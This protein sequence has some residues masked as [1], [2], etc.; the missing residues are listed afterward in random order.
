MAYSMMKDSVERRLKSPKSAEFPGI[1]ESAGHVK[2]LGNQNYR[3][4]SWVD[5]QNSF[6]ANI[7]TYFVGEIKETSDNQWNL[8]KLEFVQK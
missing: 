7:T 3:I 1:F 2:Y 8:I 6:G 5:A 4:V